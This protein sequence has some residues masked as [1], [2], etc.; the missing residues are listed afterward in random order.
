[1]LA[2]RLGAFAVDLLKDG[3]SGCAVGIENNRLIE[4]KFDKIFE[5]EH[6]IDRA[7]YKLSQE[8]SI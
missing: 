7:L 3:V 8:L 4:T 6:Q 5:E 2:S 1:M